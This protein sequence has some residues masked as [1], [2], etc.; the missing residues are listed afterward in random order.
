MIEQK[1]RGVKRW[2][3]VGAG[4]CLLV[5][6][7]AGLFLPVIQGLLCIASGLTLLSTEY[8]WA[9]VCLAWIKRKIRL[10]KKEGCTQHQSEAVVQ[11]PAVHV[12]GEDP[13]HEKPQ[14]QAVSAT[15]VW[16]DRGE[17]SLSLLP[18]A[19]AQAGEEGGKARCC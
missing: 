18:S 9:G 1:R 3:T 4:W 13:P 5:V 8:R 15:T 17:Q 11:L 14:R 10:H 19:S 16:L 7:V 2:L 6:G 12:L